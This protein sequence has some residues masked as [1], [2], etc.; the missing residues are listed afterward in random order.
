MERK[1]LP[2]GRTEVEV[3]VE[4]VG[5]RDTGSGKGMRTVKAHQGVLNL[6]RTRGIHEDAQGQDQWIRNDHRSD[7]MTQK[8]VH[9]DEEDAALPII[10]MIGYMRAMTI[11]AI[12]KEAALEILNEDADKRMVTTKGQGGVRKGIRV[13]SRDTPF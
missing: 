6:S 13:P 7:R 3:E 2:S 1:S 10:D 12:V 4:T 8:G 11:S 9:H 5:A